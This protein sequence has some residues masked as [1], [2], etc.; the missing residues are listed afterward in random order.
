MS[1]Q[2]GDVLEAD[3]ADLGRPRNARPPGDETCLQF[4]VV[5]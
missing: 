4:G 1:D 3:L 2:R 5:G